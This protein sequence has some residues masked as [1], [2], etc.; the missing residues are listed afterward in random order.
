MAATFYTNDG[1]V[2][3]VGDC[4]LYTNVSNN[5]WATFMEFHSDTI[6][7]KSMK[8]AIADLP[9]PSI[10]NNITQQVYDDAKAGNEA[11]ITALETEGYWFVGDWF[12]GGLV[13]FQGSTADNIGWVLVRA[14][15]DCPNDDYEYWQ[16]YGNMS[17]NTHGLLQDPQDSQYKD[18]DFCLAFLDDFKVDGVDDNT[19]W[20]LIAGCPTIGHWVVTD[21]AVK[22]EKNSYN[23]SIQRTS[24]EAGD[25]VNNLLTFYKTTFLLNGVTKL[26]TGLPYHNKYDWWK[27]AQAPKPDPYKPGGYSQPDGGDGT[28][29]NTSIDIPVPGLPAE[30]LLN[31]G[32]IKMYQ[33]SETEMRQ[34]MN[35]IYSSP[36]SVIDNIKKL[37][38]NPMDSI[39]SFAISPI[40]PSVGAAEE[41]KFCGVG[42]NISMNKID[43]QFD[44]L[45][46]GS[47][48]YKKIIAEYFGSALDFSNYCKVSLFLPFIGFVPI[49]SDE[50]IG[51]DIGV[52]Y[53]LDF[54]TGECVAFVTIA[55][56]VDSINMKYNSV[57]H[58]YKGNFLAQA[59]VT[60][61]NFQNLYQSILSSVVA[62]GT[63]TA[64]AM[65]GNV[66]GG[67]AGVASTIGANLLG[68]KVEYQRAGTMSGNGG[69]L[70][71]YCPYLII[72][73]P[74][75]SLSSDFVDKRGYPSNLCNQITNIKGYFEII[76]GTFH[77]DITAAETIWGITK[78]ELDMI[79]EQ[80][81]AGAV[82]NE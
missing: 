8:A 23:D 68:Q 17:E 52:D 9:Y 82:Y 45:N 55:K 70:G 26:G 16:Y 31:C 12:N 1:Q 67:I 39:I 35:W 33:P 57:L 21:N 30:T 2:F 15:A 19:Q 71:E 38:V 80:L 29:D 62:I 78:Q 25:F 20:G 51:G 46:C 59:P 54:L 47:L 11:T 63:G 34:F 74:L 44:T 10:F 13:F 66:A 3:N 79:N 73:R 64:T 69:Q 24:I 14:M 6:D 18:Y 77:P 61:N 43:K 48:L 37:W 7:L 32:I 56:T 60:G 49:P 40:A 50:L 42:S 72:E 53:N 81:I 41:V 4:N 27:N 5:Q 22:Y 58:T 28:F 36:Q 75:Q 76:P 65:S